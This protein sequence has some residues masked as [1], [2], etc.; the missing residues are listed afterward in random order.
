[1]V[2][3]FRRRALLWGIYC[4]VRC[5]RLSTQLRGWRDRSPYWLYHPATT[6]LQAATYAQAL[7]WSGK[8]GGCSAVHCCD[9]LDERRNALDLGRSNSGKSGSERSVLAHS[10]VAGNAPSRIRGRAVPAEVER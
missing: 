7:L 1:M 10:S 6:L 8:A 3:G 2:P 9:A 4:L 5:S